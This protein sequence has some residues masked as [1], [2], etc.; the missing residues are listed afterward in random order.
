M[1]RKIPGKD[2]G[3]DAPYV[4][5]STGKRAGNILAVQHPIFGWVPYREWGLLRVVEKGIR[6]IGFLTFISWVGLTIMFKKGLIDTFERFFEWL[7]SIDEARI[8]AAEFWKTGVF[9][10]NVREALGPVGEILFPFPGAE[11]EIA[12]RIPFIDE[13]LKWFWAA[14]AA[15]ITITVGMPLA[16]VVL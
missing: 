1:A 15:A 14:V 16:K 4:R 5:V 11:R 6:T 10:S 13:P 3:I 2:L 7:Q 9:P 12:K 8:V